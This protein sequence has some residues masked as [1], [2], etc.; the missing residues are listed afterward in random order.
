MYKHA[1][2]SFLEF[3]INALHNYIKKLPNIWQVIRHALQNCIK[4]I[5]NI[6]K[7]VRQMW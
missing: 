4:K 1:I 3:C 5:K 2:T 6:W 7:V